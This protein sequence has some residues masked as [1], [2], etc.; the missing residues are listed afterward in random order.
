MIHNNSI[1]I[2]TPTYN[3]EPYLLRLYNNL[4]LQTEKSFDWVIVDDG[5]VD[6]TRNI[7]KQW[8]KESPFKIIYFYKENGGK[9]TALNLAIDFVTTELIFIV[10]SD[11]ILTINAIKIIRDD[12]VNYNNLNLIGLMY[13]RANSKGEILGDK[14]PV[15]NEITTYT[16]SRLVQK[17]TG[18]KAEVWK[19]RI[20]KD[21]LFPEFVGERFFSEQ[22]VYAKISSLGK[23]IAMN[24]VIYYCEYLEDGLSKKI[25]SLQTKNPKGA[26]LNAMELSNRDFG[27][28]RRLKSGIQIVAF[29]IIS[30][31]NPSLK[32]KE[33][34]YLPY[35]LI[36]IFIG[37]L[38]AIFYQFLYI[39][40]ENA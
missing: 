40:N 21:N 34:G 36:Y 11:D 20:L 6:N 10:D 1:S 4:L 7:V 37:F 17:V 25:R 14:F 39:S 23:V 15:D 29:S 24:K 16:Q 32:L 28:M 13:L 38:L 8:Q 19:T 9:H 26:L 35:N 18:D 22:Y 33:S 27:F 12:W 30:N 5:S 31:Q 2:I 3:R